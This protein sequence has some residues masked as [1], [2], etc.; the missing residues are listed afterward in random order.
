MLGNK[1]TKALNKVKDYIKSLEEGIEIN[2]AHCEEAER[3]KAE[4]QTEINEKQSEIKAAQSLI[5]K[6]S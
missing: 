2:L 1:L 3:K 4:L 6:L 5:E